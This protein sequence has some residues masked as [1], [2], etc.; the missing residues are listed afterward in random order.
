MFAGFNLHQLIIIHD[1]SFM[2]IDF[3]DYF[4]VAL[5]RLRLLD[6]FFVFSLFFVY[7]EEAAF[8]G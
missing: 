6:R 1:A 4:D 8:D 3:L 2:L 7:F 5:V